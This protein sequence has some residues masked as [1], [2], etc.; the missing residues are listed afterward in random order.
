MDEK[1]E[2]SIGSKGCHVVEV[3]RDVNE[4]RGRPGLAKE[5]GRGFVLC[6]V[7]RERI[8]RV[9]EGR[10][11]VGRELGHVR[12]ILCGLLCRSLDVGGLSR[13]LRGVGQDWWV[14]WMYLEQVASRLGGI[15]MH[16]ALLSHFLN[17]HIRLLTSATYVLTRHPSI[18]KPLDSIRLQ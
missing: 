2:Y 9:E 1:G 12:G 6:W 17:Q 18:F 13:A 16:V 15:R 11:W 7:D 8:R 5:D 14:L 10:R 3:W 4:L